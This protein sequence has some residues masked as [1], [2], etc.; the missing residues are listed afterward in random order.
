[1]V[2]QPHDATTT[3]DVAIH[4]TDAQGLHQ[5]QQYLPYF[6]LLD[7][8][9]MFRSSISSSSDHATHACGNG[10]Y[11]NSDEEP[12]MMSESQISV[13]VKSKSDAAR[14][15]AFAISVSAL[16]NESGTENQAEVVSLPCYFLQYL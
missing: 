2:Q 10:K 15:H 13:T 1:M 4:K 8:D 9:V 3:A 5:P 11:Q 6:S 16:D 12:V 14:M 7:E